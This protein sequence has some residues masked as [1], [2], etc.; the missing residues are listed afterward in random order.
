MQNRKFPYILRKYAIFIVLLLGLLY[1]LIFRVLAPTPASRIADALG[2]VL[3]RGTQAVEY[4]DTHGGFHGDGATYAVLDLGEELTDLLADKL[5]ANENWHA[6][7]LSDDMRIIFYGLTRMEDGAPYTYAPVVPEGTIVPE[8]ERGY[9][10]LIDRQ[11]GKSGSIFDKSRYSQ[12][13][14]AAILDTDS[15]LLYYIAEDT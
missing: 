1:L 10:R 5:A 9:W 3:P 11:E 4:A 13:F 2:L 12:N 8:I 6:L 7:P 15:G 14:T